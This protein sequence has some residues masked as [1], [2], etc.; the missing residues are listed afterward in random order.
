M[1]Y[2]VHHVFTKLTEGRV[3]VLERGGVY[4][5]GF[6][7]GE[8]MAGSRCVHWLWLSDFSRSSKKIVVL[9]GFRYT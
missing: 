2:A 6:A 7:E 8:S 1:A 3:G 4:A 5:E 9:L